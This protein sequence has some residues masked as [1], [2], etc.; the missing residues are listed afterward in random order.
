MKGVKIT[1]FS[2]IVAGFALENWLPL[3]ASTRKNERDSILMKI[4][5]WN[6]WLLYSTVTIIPLTIFLIFSL[7]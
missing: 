1:R 6:L 5:N 3:K 4:I 7:S 2:F